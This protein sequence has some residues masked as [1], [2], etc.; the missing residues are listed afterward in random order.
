MMDRRS[1]IATLI[2]VPATSLVVG[3]AQWAQAAPPRASRPRLALPTADQT[4]WQD[5]EIGMFVHF[6][7]NTWQNSEYDNL[8]TPL[9][10]MNPS[11]LNTD[12]WAEC[13]VSLGAKYILFVAKHVGGFCMWQTHT[14][15]YG[16][17]NTPWQGGRGDVL[18]DVAASCKRYKL[19]LGVY[20]SPQDRKFGAGLGGK[21]KA[22]EQQRTYNALY[23][24]Q[25]TEVLS[26]YGEM[27]E[28]WFDGSIVVPVGDIL[29]RYAPNAMIFQGP[30]ATVRWV[31][32]EQGFAPYPAWNPIAP[33]DAET[34]VATSIQGDPNGSVWLPNE[35]DVSILRPD[36]FWSPQKERNLLSH[37]QLVEI[38]YRS[39]G[40]GVQWILN[41]PPDSS[42]LMPKENCLRV[43]E[44]GD[45][46][47]QRFGRSLA[48]TTG[49]GERIQLSLPSPSQIDH[50]IL[51][52]NCS[53]GQRVRAYRL[54]GRAN[55]G[56]IVLGTGTAIG[57][58]RIQPITPT[59]LHAVRLV[60]TESAGRPEIRRMAVFNT[61]VKPP[62]TWDAPVR[63]WA[64]NEVGSWKNHDF[65][66][67]LSGKVAV[68]AQYRLR[69]VPQGGE[70]LAVEDP[71]LLIGDLPQPDLLRRAKGHADALILT[72]T[73][74]DEKIVIKGRVRGP[75]QGTL[76]LQKL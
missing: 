25:L 42:G 36:W 75:E 61:G 3:N 74:V 44:F 66:V 12:Q 4:A 19:K 27:V 65:A 23:R 73:G 31:G 47:R 49:S 48:E 76:L 18:A 59:F 62:S 38:Y 72:I 14:T 41:L 70:K 56:W 10:A 15:N 17:R 30:E 13:A 37:D 54:E 24:Q 5:M 7:P 22:P 28:V 53:L 57:H 43:K 11:D 45:D 50:V 21:C 68:A 26:R 9:S 2:G 1:F 32:N 40:H 16:I 63:V 71:V 20:L 33:A 60:V 69:F 67:D 6:A 29:K 39:V 8:S 51:Q 64:A 55:A 34:G 58:K 46:I 52:E 35:A